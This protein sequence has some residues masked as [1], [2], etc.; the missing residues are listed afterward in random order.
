MVTI[1]FQGPDLAGWLSDKAFH[2]NILEVICNVYKTNMLILII[3]LKIAHLESKKFCKEACI[4]L[5]PPVHMK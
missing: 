3:W 4:Y 2:S 5:P 1:T